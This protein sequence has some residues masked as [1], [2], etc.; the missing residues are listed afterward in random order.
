M[1]LRAA[2]PAVF[3]F[4]LAR[5]S[6]THCWQQRPAARPSSSMAGIIGAKDHYID[7]EQSKLHARVNLAYVKLC[8]RGKHWVSM[9]SSSHKE[10]ERWL[11]AAT[12]AAEAA[13]RQHEVRSGQLVA[14]LSALISACILALLSFYAE[15]EDS[16]CRD[17]NV[18][19]RMTSRLFQTTRP[20]L[21]RYR[22]SIAQFDRAA[23]LL[24]SAF[25][26][27]EAYCFYAGY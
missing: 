4:V 2:P 19:G 10:H 17:W 5:V 3:Q 23:L 22:T 7:R 8:S 15:A 11:N 26:A 20:L 13:L 12:D 14:V 6:Q 18:I 16:L 24:C 25:S 9:L 27:A 1:K 21:V